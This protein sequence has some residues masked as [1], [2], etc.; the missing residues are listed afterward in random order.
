MHKRLMITG[1]SGVGKTTLARHISEAYDIP[2]I[3]SSAK[4]VWPS[5]GFKNHLQAHEESIKNKHV[6]VQYQ[7]AI[8][9]QR[10]DTLKGHNYITDRSPIDNMAYIMMQ[11][12]F[13]L[14]ECE[15]LD[16]ISECSKGMMLCDGLIFIRWNGEIELENDHNRIVN[17][18]FQAYTDAIIEWIIND[19]V[20][21]RVCPIL[22]LTQ[23]DFTYRVTTTHTWLKE[24]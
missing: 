3:T 12:G 21:F 9:K 22:E 15:T 6:G 19:L 2:F 11:L 20:V 10:L 5:F 8:L 1:A 18:F 17:P 4:A 24:L 23:W 13:G 7:W 14:T 16:F